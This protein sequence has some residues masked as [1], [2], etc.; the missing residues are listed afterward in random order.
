M[1]PIRIY[2]HNTWKLSI[3]TSKFG[4]KLIKLRKIKDSTISHFDET[5]LIQS[6]ELNVM[7][8]THSH[9]IQTCVAN[10]NLNLTPE[11]FSQDE[12]DVRPNNW[13]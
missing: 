11:T 2:F 9:L 5:S 13:G 12:L 10:L 7:E 3:I 6:L 1:Y 4:T 8:T